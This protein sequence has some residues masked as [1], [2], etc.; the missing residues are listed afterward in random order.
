MENLMFFAALDYACFIQGIIIKC[1]ISVKQVSFVQGVINH[2]RKAS[3]KQ[4]VPKGRSHLLTLLSFYPQWELNK[5]V[6]YVSYV[7]YV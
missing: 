7:S 4:K 3:T 1:E 2:L 5:Q 6:S